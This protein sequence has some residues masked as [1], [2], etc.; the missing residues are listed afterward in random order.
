MS[1]ATPCLPTTGWVVL[2]GEPGLSPPVLGTY[3]VD[4]RMGFDGV[5]EDFGG[6]G[7]GG[8]KMEVMVVE[9][10]VE[11]VMRAEVVLMMEFGCGERWWWYRWW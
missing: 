2:V 5:G 9:V 1:E 11:E 8:D 6:D 3:K 10:Q 7:G 4:S